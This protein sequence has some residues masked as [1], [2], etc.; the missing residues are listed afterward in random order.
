MT[1][2]LKHYLQT[3]H[4]TKKSEIGLSST[5]VQ[6]QLFCAFHSEEPDLNTGSVTFILLLHKNYRPLILWMITNKVFTAYR[7]KMWKIWSSE[8][9]TPFILLPV[10]FKIWMFFS[11]FKTDWDPSECISSGTLILLNQNPRI[12]N[13]SKFKC[14]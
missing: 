1:V 11:K 10:F 8:F 3:I 4:I 5:W 6:W 7:S 2:K 13:W 14:N 9:Q 12:A